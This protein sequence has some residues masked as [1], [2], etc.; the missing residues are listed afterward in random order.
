MTA[1]II[2]GAGV[3]PAPTRFGRFAGLR[4]LFRKDTREWIRGKRAW[5]VLIVTAAFMVLTAA[6][7][8][9]TSQIAHALPGEIPADKIG[10]L[11][12]VD[13]LL[14]AVSSQIFVIAAIFAV[15]GLMAREREA[16]TL[17]WVASKPVTRASI[18]VSK[19]AS[20]TAVLGIAAAVV[21]LAVT[22]AV[23]TILYGMLPMALVLAVAAG[24]VAVIAF[25]AALG[26]ALGTVVPGQPATIAAAFGVFALMP[27]IAGLIP[28]PIAEY[29]PTSILP[30]LAGAV[31]GASVSAATPVAWAI[32]TGGLAALAIRQMG[33]L[34]L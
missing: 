21:P 2:E 23:V 15:G 17:A 27:V 30:W 8:W 3:A 34:E 32:A 5:V 25:F 7:S 12:P 31:S 24:M 4:A 1:S 33:R 28:F 18:W 22:A 26:L 13:N 16:G 19:W 6:N 11:V 10:S 14:V 9:I 29:L 20:S